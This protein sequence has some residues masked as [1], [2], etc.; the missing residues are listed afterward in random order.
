MTIDQIL[1]KLKIRW[2]WIVILVI[3]ASLFSF[4]ISKESYQV[5]LT[6]GLNFNQ[7]QFLENKNDSG[8]TYLDSL[9]IFSNFLTTSFA[10][11]FIQN[12][13]ATELN[14]EFLVVP[15]KS[16]FEIQ[17]IGNGFVT[18]SWK[19]DSVQNAQKF[20]EATQKTYKNQ[21][22]Q[23]WN[24]G[25]LANFEVKA[26]ENFEPIILKTSVPVQTRLLPI[27]A[28]FILGSILAIIIPKRQVIDSN[29]SDSK[30][31][32]ESSKEKSKTK[33]A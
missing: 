6:F 31:K 24:Q 19:T 12:Q 33:I 30:E 22:V 27:L 25:K 32:E 13:I 23:S 1:D 9:P 14:Q 17:N 28:G 16:F 10:S 7:S 21:I 8:K 5:S 20:V 26:I 11:T 18:L 3:F 29:M 4:L 2:F 15:K